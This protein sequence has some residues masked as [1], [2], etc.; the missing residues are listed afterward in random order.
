[1]NRLIG[2]VLVAVACVGLASAGSAQAQWNDP[3]VVEALK[4]IERD[5]GQAMVAVRPREAQSD[6][7]RRLDQHRGLRR[8]CHERESAAQRQ[9]RRRPARSA[10]TGTHGRASE[11]QC[12]RG[13]RQCYREANPGRKRRERRVRLDGPHGE[14]QRHMGRYSQCGR[15]SEM[16][17]AFHDSDALVS[18]KGT[19]RNVNAG[20][21]GRHGKRWHAWQQRQR[22]FCKLQ[23]LQ[24]VIGFESH[25]LRQPSPIARLAR[26]FG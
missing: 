18:L 12:R 13:A 15:E 7:R 4:Q 10:R 14:A 3:A 16:T 1:M 8:R 19:A 11:G 26:G 24:K 21:P 20:A 23:N 25:P 22:G 9:V 2:R 5:M 6:L 17:I